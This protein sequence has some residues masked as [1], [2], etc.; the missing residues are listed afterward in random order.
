VGQRGNFL[1]NP[2]RH[3][4]SIA[5][6]R[7]RLRKGNTACLTTGADGSKKKTPNTGKREAANKPQTLTNQTWAALARGN[8]KKKKNIRKERGAPCPPESGQTEKVH[9]RQ[10]HTGGI[11]EVD[12]PAA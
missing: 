3:R 4:G 1:E 5:A 9:I 11:I 8:Q 6:G 2:F 12:E 7:E 10:R